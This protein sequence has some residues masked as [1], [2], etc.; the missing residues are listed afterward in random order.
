MEDLEFEISHIKDRLKYGNC[1][2]EFNN[3]YSSE[4]MAHACERFPEV[5]QWWNT[6][7]TS[8]DRWRYGYLKRQWQLISARISCLAA[9]RSVESVVG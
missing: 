9:E 1:G 8:N 3:R 7:I 4:A 5:R 6:R 2:F